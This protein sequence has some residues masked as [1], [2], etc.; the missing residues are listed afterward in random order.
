M[1]PATSPATPSAVTAESIYFDSGKVE[2]IVLLKNKVG[3]VTG[4]GSGMGRGCALRFAKEGA[5]L[6]LFDLSENGLAETKALI[7]ES[8]QGAEVLCCKVDVSDENQVKQAIEAVAAQFGKL[9][10]AHNNAG[11]GHLGKTVGDLPSE[12]WERVLRV[13]LFGAFYCA[14]YEVQEMLK[15]D[16]PCSILFTAS[17]G[18]LMGTPHS[19]EYNASKHGV[20]GLMKALACDYAD[21][22]IRS[23]A[24]CP[25]AIDTPMW[26]GGPGKEF[27]GNP[28]GLAK[29]NATRNLMRRLGTVEEIETDKSRV[30]VI[31]SMFG[32]ETPVDLDFDQVEAV[33]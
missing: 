25:G 27:Q 1:P 22:G 13:N 20:I 19:C 12:V 24:I 9:H 11:I 10:F 6:G 17:V 14:K 23:N 28:E 3:I 26:E 16:D 32:R 30:R 33:K 18:G 31:V 5:K 29:F 8:C 21:Q 7:E 15:H 4:A 2:Y